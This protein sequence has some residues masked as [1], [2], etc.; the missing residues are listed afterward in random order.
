[1]SSKEIVKKFF[2]FSIGTWIGALL[3]III[4][5]V[6]THL[7]SPEEYGKASMFTLAINIS[8]IFVLLGSDQSFVR[9]YYERKP[10]LLLGN[11]VKISSIV[12]FFVA[13]ILV[14]IRKPLSI[15]LFGGYYSIIVLLIIFTLILN[16]INRYSQLILRMEQKGILFSIFE[17]ELRLVELFA[18]IMFYYLVGGSFEFLIYSKVIA[19]IVVAVLGIIVVRKSWISIEFDKRI[20]KSSTKEILKF[21]Y[22][23][24]FSTAITWLFQATDRLAINSWSSADELGIYV[25]AFNVVMGLNLLQV[26]F[27]NYWIPLSLEKFLKG[28]KYQNKIFFKKA[29]DLISIIMILSVLI[30]ILFKNWII[31]ILG[32]EYFN[33]VYLIPLLVFGPF[34]KTVSESTGN[35]I[36]FYKKVH[37]TLI[38]SLI[39][40]VFNIIGNYLLVPKFGGKG[41]A[42]STSIS[43]IIY[44]IIRTHISKY[45][46]NISYNLV[47]FY[48]IMF[49]ILIYSLYSSFTEYDY[50]NF[51]FGF[52]LIILS[53]FTYRYTLVNAFKLLLKVIFSR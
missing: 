5:P 46:Y 6:I 44:F 29:N 50:W 38:I 20:N 42:I 1:M 48:G 13:A 49:L 31:K 25:S 24:A 11:S 21:G 32:S 47:K 30:I 19:Y 3:S 28:D 12:L 16:I 41:A 8:L 23:L 15:Y 17:V 36:R 53:L 18:I 14:L 43:Y 26:S 35:G 7:F 9:F 22:P 4:V 40:C 39:I 33:A 51:I 2:S 10:N 52:I 34:M 45:F 37:W 27:T